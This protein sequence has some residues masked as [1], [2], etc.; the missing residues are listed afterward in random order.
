MPTSPKLRKRTLTPGKARQ[1]APP[2]APRRNAEPR[3]AGRYMPAVERAIEAVG[4]E[5]EV[6]RRLGISQPSVHGWK[7]RK[8]CPAERVPWLS[9][10]SGVSKHELRPDLY[11]RGEV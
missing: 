6:A 4:G 5:A 2:A 7:Q 3:A 8:R 1:A 10:A 11:K 9:E